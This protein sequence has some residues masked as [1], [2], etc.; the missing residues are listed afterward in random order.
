VVEWAVTNPSIFEHIIPIACNSFHSPWGIA[1][2]E[3]QR[4]AIEADATWKDN[5]QRAGGEG[6][7][8]ARAIGMLSYRSYETFSHTQAEK[9]NEK[10]DDFRAATYQRYQGQKLVNRFNA[11]SYWRFTKMMDSHNVGRG[12]VSVKEALSSIQAKTLVVGIDSD[13]LFPVSEQKFL[14]ENIPGAHYQE[15]TS[16]YGHDGFL[17]EFDQLDTILKQF[18]LR[19]KTSTVLS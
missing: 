8:A 15:I 14:A 11:L 16:L 6:L 13:I 17:V 5:D 1:F 7:K 12:R 3:A 18:Y 4:M 2:N 19:K 10:F 9:T